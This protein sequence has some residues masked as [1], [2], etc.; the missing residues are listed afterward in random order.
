M[1]RQDD[2]SLG[3]DAVIR[4]DRD[5]CESIGIFI[6]RYRHLVHVT[7]RLSVWELRTTAGLRF[8]AHHGCGEG[9][10]RESFG[11]HSYD[12]IKVC[13]NTEMHQQGQGQAD[14]AAN[15]CSVAMLVL[16]HQ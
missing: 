4:R 10:E 16:L 7:C 3:V 12:G 13:C 14:R 15:L 8:G 9:E 11:L 6:C 1:K 5:E 2:L